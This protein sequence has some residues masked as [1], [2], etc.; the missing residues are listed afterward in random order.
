MEVVGSD[1]VAVHPY[2][3]THL[4]V[5]IGIYQLSSNLI[6]LKLIIQIGQRYHV[7]VSATRPLP[8]TNYW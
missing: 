8:D 4:L 5:G 7:L 1:F 3:T 6:E 2:K